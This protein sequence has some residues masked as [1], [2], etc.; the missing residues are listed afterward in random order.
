MNKKI[1]I[2]CQAKGG[3]GK[4]ILS[5]LTALSMYEDDNCLFVD[6]DSSTQTSTR[7]LKFLGEDR[8]ETISL[9]DS[10]G[11][12]IRD[13]LISYLESIKDTPFHTVVFDLGA[14][15]SEQLP[16]LFQHDVPLQEL[17]EE[18]GFDFQFNVV[19][20]GGGAYAA[21]MD[22]L[23]KLI[24]ALGNEFKIE[25]WQSKTSFNSFP[26]LGEELKSIAGKL[27][28]NL[29]TFGNFSP[30]SDIG[31]TILNGIR[32]GY[33]LQQYSVG[34][35]IRLSSEIKNIRKHG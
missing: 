31:S 22:Y 18:L 27:D 9:L 17:A 20:G 16:A 10:E 25:L 32:L 26:E 7:Q 35:R 3:V 5:Y 34:S 30:N 11:I 8:T 1:L 33:T 29:I 14:P 4:S 28:L 21:S 15:E 12:L 6:C 13:K 19:I 24:T 2:I 23:G